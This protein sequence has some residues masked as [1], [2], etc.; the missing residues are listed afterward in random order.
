MAGSLISMSRIMKVMQLL[1]L[2]PLALIAV[3]SSMYAQAPLR[4]GVV[5]LVHGHV[6]G[7]FSTTLN[8]SDV[9]IAGIAEPDRQ[10]F[11]RYAQQYHLDPNLYFYTLTNGDFKY[12]A[13][14]HP[15]SIL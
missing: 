9:Q 5:G 3:S 14:S 8:R 10:L 13:E 1:R 7:F 12:V 2:A 6:A 11:N 4:I 15:S